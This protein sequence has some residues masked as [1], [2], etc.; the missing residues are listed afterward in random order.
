M[1]GLDLYKLG[2]R[3]LAFIDRNRAA[4]VETAAPRRVRNI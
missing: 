4:R 1:A 3:L 2:P